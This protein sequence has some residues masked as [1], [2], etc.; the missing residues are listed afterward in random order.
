MKKG[1]IA[2]LLLG[3]LAATVTVA[4][5]AEA[6]DPQKGPVQVAGL[7]DWFRRRATD[8]EIRTGIKT[9]IWNSD[10]MDNAKVNV[11]V[12]NGNVVLR[13]AV[14]TQAQKNLATQIARS[15]DG[16][17]SVDNQ[18]TVTRPGDVPDDNTL[19]KAGEK[20]DNHQTSTRIR[21]KIL[22]AG[23]YEGNDIDITTVNDVVVLEGRVN[24]A[25]QA[26]RISQLARETS[27]V[28]KVINKL[29]VQTK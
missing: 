8:T 28:Q 19:D 23:L 6:T 15:K 9:D 5:W 17:K 26:N 7:G 21:A 24:T 4:S 10:R 18:L 13:G 11:D 1:I 25:E 29:K 22:G 20:I 3:Q 12:S 16:V 27:G 2:G 14:T